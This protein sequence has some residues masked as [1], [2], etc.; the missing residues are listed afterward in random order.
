M[1]AFAALIR[2]KRGKKRLSQE[3]L[4]GDVFGDPARKGDISRIENARTT[5]QEATIQK[6][7]TAL[8]ISEAELAPI[9]MAR[10]SAKQ[11]DQIP[12]LSRDELELLANRFEVEKAHDLSDADLRSFLNQKAEEYRDYRA[13]I[14]LLDDR[15][16][17]IA[18]LKGAA[19]DA[20]AKLDFDE[21]E[22]LISRVDEVETEIAAETKEAGA[23]NA[24]LRN[25]P[26]DAYTILTA[27]ADSFASI[28]P[29]EPANR[30]HDYMQ[31]LFYHG[32]RYGG[33]GIP[34]AVQMIRDALIKA[35]RDASPETWAMCQNA[36]GA[37]L[38]EQG[39]RT[40]GEAG[41]QLLAEAVTA[42]RDALTVT[43][44][45]DHPVGWAGT[46]YNL[47]ECELARADP[48]SHLRAAM[49]H[50]EAALTVYGP[51]HMPYRFD[52]AIKLRDRIKARLS[53]A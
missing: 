41:T 7:C 23:A 15:V 44:R 29:L 49:D 21:V 52:E 32:L 33:E 42:C 13:Q 10:A 1:P 27:A 31:Q 24:L 18:N 3:T 50:V 53:G 37:S 22:S 6:L 30:R 16:A 25:R 38:Q 26:Q 45:A 8:D 12:T 4:A 46:Q 9:R 51:E 2:A 28:D 35:P 17:A 36:L 40:G 43:T 19:Q 39:T 11:L 34:L 14:D 47:A 5:P 48:A 20:A